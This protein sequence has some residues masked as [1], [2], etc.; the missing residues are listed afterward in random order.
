MKKEVI[1]EIYGCSFEPIG[2]CTRFLDIS[3]VSLYIK[4]T[5][6]DHPGYILLYLV[7]VCLLLSMYVYSYCSSMY[8]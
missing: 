2:S 7:Y 5:D 8:S 6:L 4:H 1:S 3:A